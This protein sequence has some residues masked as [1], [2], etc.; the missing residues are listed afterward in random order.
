M[1]A[2]LH[3]AAGNIADLLDFNIT[4]TSGVRSAEEQA[5]AMFTKIE[6]GDD[7]IAV[8]A[9]DSFA[10][11]VM[12]A[13]PNLDQAT[14]FVQSYF[15]LGKGSNHGRGDALDIRTT[16]GDSNRLSSSE[17]LA[18][19][20]ATK[21]LGYTPYQEYSPPHLHVKVGS[22]NVKKNNLLFM[23]MVLGGLWIFLS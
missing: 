8:Y 7:L 12:D 3:A 16:G 18:L 11:G 21:D 5:R 4:I 9:D 1:D 13:H 19:I 14:T 17:I 10:Q 6:L 15:N 23:A 2:N 22:D 20:Q